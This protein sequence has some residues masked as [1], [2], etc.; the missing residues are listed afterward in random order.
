MQSNDHFPR[1]EFADKNQMSA[2]L[3]E[4]FNQWILFRIVFS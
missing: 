3:Y 4:E 2:N 1:I